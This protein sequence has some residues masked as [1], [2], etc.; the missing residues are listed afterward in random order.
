MGCSPLF[1]IFL[2]LKQP[3]TSPLRRSTRKRKTTSV[4]TA[5]YKEVDSDEEEHEKKVL[6]SAPRDEEPED[7]ASSTRTNARPGRK[8]SRPE[9]DVQEYGDWRIMSAIDY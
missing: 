6:R 7:E 2:I 4:P 8:F 1:S 5:S 3:Q 9:D